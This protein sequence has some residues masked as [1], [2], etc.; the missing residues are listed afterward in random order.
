MSIV[1]VKY[2]PFVLAAICV[3][4]L[5]Q[6]K[7]EISFYRWVKT[8]WFYSRKFRVFFSSLLKLFGLSLLI[9][10]LLDFRGEEEKIKLQV[11]DQKTIILIDSSASML[12]E[13]I[14]PN[15]F[16]KALIL[17]RHFIKQ[18][19]GHQVSVLVFSDTHKRLVPFTDDF[20]LLESRVA[21][22]DDLD[23]KDGGS[24]LSQA[25][26]ESL[27]YF[28]EVTGDA[29]TPQ[30]NILVFT[31]SEENG[32]Q[33]N[34]SK[35]LSKINLAIVGL[36]TAKGAPIPIRFKDGK[37]Q[38]NKRHNGQEVITKLDEE[39]MKSF[40]KTFKNFKYWIALSYSIP[41]DEILNFFRDKVSAGSQERDHVSRPVKM[42]FVVLPALILIFL[43]IV[44]KW[45]NAFK[46][47][48]I[49]LI[50]IGPLGSFSQEEQEEA[51]LK[52]KEEFWKKHSES[53]DELE[54]GRLSENDTLK[55]GEEALRAKIYDNA[56]LIY[57][58]VTGGKDKQEDLETLFNQATAELANKKV[59]EASDLVD[60]FQQ[61]A[62]SRNSNETV[63]YSK[64][65]RE[66]MLLAI[67]QK[68]E[69]QAK[70]EQKKKEQEEKQKQKGDKQSQQGEGEG[71][72]QSGEGNEDEKEKQKESKGKEKEDQKKKEA[73]KNNE[74]KKEEKKGESQK[75]REERIRQQKKMVKVPSLLKQLLN[76][77]RDLQKKNIDPRTNSTKWKTGKDGKQIDQSKKDW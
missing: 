4:F 64:K 48:G 8:Y 22:L 26:F 60:K 12:A 6:I 52:M 43:S 30:G 41:T 37:F 63:E 73:E 5:I 70:E 65:L 58:G 66:N 16:K 68:L 45:G 11:S 56:R 35:D 59:E 61:L 55:L 25:I 40:S 10:S 2:I 76:E 7:L 50:L 24:N 19:Y 62:E 28:S 54:K 67:N 3:L 32:E 75:E 72:K 47:L 71:D 53:F 33:I 74:E 77:D 31:D 36:G 42:H 46:A 15:R 39:Q 14:R 69:A 13:D 57:R 34:I 9:L 29:K 21:G 51:Y 17:A 23:L 49:I 18:A 27:A 38:G 20:D 1:Y 44:L